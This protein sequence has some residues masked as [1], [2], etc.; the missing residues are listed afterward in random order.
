MLNNRSYKPAEKIPIEVRTISQPDPAWA[1]THHAFIVFFNGRFFAM[2]SQGRFNE[3][4]CGQRVMI[5]HSDDF[6]RWSEPEP[7]VDSIKGEHSDMVLTAGGFYTDGDTLAA[8]YFAYEYTKESIR[9]GNRLPEEQCQRSKSVSYLITSKDGFNWSSA[10]IIPVC[11]NINHPPQPTDSGRLIIAGASEFPYTDDPTGISGW[12]R[13]G[14]PQNAVPDAKKQGAQLICEGSFYQTDDRALHMVVRSD[15][16]WLWCSDSHDDGVT[17]GPLY[18][19]QFTDD[20]AKFHFGRLPD[21]RFYYIGNPIRGRLRNPL[22]LCLSVD[23]E[24]F[25]RQY[26]LGDTPY[27]RQFPGLY[28]GGHF[29]YPHSLVRNGYL[30]VIYSKQKEYVEIC[31]C[32]LE[33]ITEK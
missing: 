5:S 27:R 25:D 10:A 21:G 26:I 3:D 9:D 23:G 24:N 7:L 19:T 20:S 33:D 29:G 17:W 12:Q 32:R 11:P 30:Y 6:Y 15:T 18:P 2:W 31:R 13:S 16:L 1:Y 4:D 28:K 14:L 8:Y 22:M